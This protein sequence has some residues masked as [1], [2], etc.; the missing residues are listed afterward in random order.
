MLRCRNCRQR[1]HIRAQYPRKKVLGKKKSAEKARW[2][3]E[4]HGKKTK[5]EHQDWVRTFQETREASPLTPRYNLRS[6]PSESSK[7]FERGHHSCQQPKLNSNT[8]S[9]LTICFTCHQPGHKFYE[10]PE[11][12]TQMSTQAPRTTS[13][14]AQTPHTTNRNQPLPR[15]PTEEDI[16]R[17]PDDMTC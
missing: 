1:G 13:K 6:S 9:A 14:P 5:T 3:N 11:K 4:H 16:G 10:C 12:E 7:N 8:R 17:T 15:R 2:E